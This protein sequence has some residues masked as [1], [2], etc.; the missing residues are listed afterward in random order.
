MV[1]EEFAASHADEGGVQKY[2]WL[3]SDLF[4]QRTW[5]LPSA[6]RSADPRT[7]SGEWDRVTRSGFALRSL[8][9]G[10]LK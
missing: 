2:A 9:A 8:M 10:G 4:Q 3:G 1:S 7:F 5:R 6:K